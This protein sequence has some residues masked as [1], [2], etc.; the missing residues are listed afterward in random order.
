MK[1]ILLGALIALLPITGFT[2]TVLGVQVGVGT[3]SH[4]PS[5]SITA[6]VNG[7]GTSADLKNELNL[8]KKTEGYTY[9]VIEHPVPLVPNL[10]FVNTKLSSSGSGTANSSFD[11]NGTTYN[12]S[13]NLTTSLQFDQT[14]TILYY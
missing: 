1:K 4:D 10:K 7:T 6:S 14:D 3:W 13:T 2:A 9:I 12:T 8:S 11:F 5:G